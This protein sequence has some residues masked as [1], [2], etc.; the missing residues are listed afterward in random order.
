MTSFTTRRRVPHSPRQMFD[1]VADVEHYPEFLPLC[2][3]LKVHSRKRDGACE[4]VLATMVA[5]YGPVHESFTSRVRLD[6]E[7]PRVDVAYEDGPFS[8]LENRWLFHPLPQGGTEVEFFISYE[9]KSMMLQMLMGAMFDKAF[10]KFADAFEERARLVYGGRGA[11][12]Q[13]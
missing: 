1:L 9:F 12:A 6:P 11:T 5:G 10:A 2:E 7:T 13:S 4:V 3:S 8:H